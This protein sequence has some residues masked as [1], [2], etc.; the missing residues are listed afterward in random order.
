VAE[1]WCVSIAIATFGHDSMVDTMVY[2]LLPPNIRLQTCVKMN[3]FTHYRVSRLYV[4]FML[5][6]SVFF[7]TSLTSHGFNSRHFSAFTGCSHHRSPSSATTGTHFATANIYPS[8]RSV[9][10][11]S[12]SSPRFVSFWDCAT[13]MRQNHVPKNEETRPAH[14]NGLDSRLYLAALEATHH[15][16]KRVL[17]T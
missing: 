9:S 11:L 12:T 10:L 15:V 14:H 3:Y 16:T 13:H 2:L 7:G 1:T 8:K 17:T 6:A 4:L 5:K